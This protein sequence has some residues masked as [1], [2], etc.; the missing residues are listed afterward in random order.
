MGRGQP[1]GFDELMIINPGFPGSGVMFLGDDGTLYQVQGLDQREV[2]TTPPQFF[3]G[4]DGTLYEMEFLGEHEARELG[5]F[6]LGEDGTLY[7]LMR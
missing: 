1:R 3:L 2:Q 7:E 5:R 6:F 4:E